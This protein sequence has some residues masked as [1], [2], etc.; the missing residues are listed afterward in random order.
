MAG[1]GKAGM[2]ADGAVAAVVVARIEAAFL[3]PFLRQRGAD[4]DEGGAFDL[5]GNR[6]LQRGQRRPD[7]A[8]VWPACPLIT[9]VGLTTPVN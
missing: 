6:G 2:G 8:L 4:E 9:T 5:L 1:A 7:Q 3:E